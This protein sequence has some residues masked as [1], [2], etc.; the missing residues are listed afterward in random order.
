MKNLKS[1]GAVG[2]GVTDD[3][4]AINAW[5][6]DL[7]ATGEEGFVPTGTYRSTERLLFP[8][9]GGGSGKTLVLRGE[10]AY[11]SR[12]D[13][14]AAPTYQGPQVHFYTVDNKPS[15][16]YPHLMDLGFT[17][18]TPGTLAA[19]GLEDFSDDIGNANL[20]N[21]FFGN[22]NSTNSPGGIALQLNYI[23]DCLFQ[24]VVCVGKVGYGVALDMRAPVF[25]T[26][27]GGSYSNA[28]MGIRIR[29]TGIAHRSS[30]TNTFIGAD[31][32]N[33]NYGLVCQNQ[34]AKSNMF[35]NTYLDIWRPDLTQPGIAG[36]HSSACGVPGI[37]MDHVTLAP[38]TNPASLLDPANQANVHIRSW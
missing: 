13:L 7:I 18:D 38:H 19:L 35:I 1:Y 21:V 36:I 5:I 16:H 22:A 2:N 12:F 4:A 24:N 30:F 29:Q 6:A 23:F 32:E 33:V 34:Y 8:L 28:H 3:E 9:P 31:I 15:S 14:S 17:S 20:T 10:G 37:T 11:K 27:Q 26:F 25:C